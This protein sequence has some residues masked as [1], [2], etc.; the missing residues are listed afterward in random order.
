VQL[1][2]CQPAR[3]LYVCKH[4]SQ[5]LCVC[6]IFLHEARAAR[7]WGRHLPPSL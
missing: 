3:P 1:V 5:L 6:A 4:R 7:D 2:C